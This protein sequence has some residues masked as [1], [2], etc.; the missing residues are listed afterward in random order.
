MEIFL[1][2]FEF[3]PRG[4]MFTVSESTPA[5]QKIENLARGRMF[6]ACRTC[7]SAG[8]LHFSPRRYTF[9]A[10]KQIR[11]VENNI[12]A[13]LRSI[14]GVENGFFLIFFHF[15]VR[16]AVFFGFSGCFFNFKISSR[17]ISYQLIG[18]VS[19]L[20]FNASAVMLHASF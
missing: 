14:F 11:R 13:G 17:M 9:P 18:R 19:N 12:P 3:L 4:C 1:N 5:D 2:F 15:L 10:S 16:G 7:T 20:I 8:K 6:S